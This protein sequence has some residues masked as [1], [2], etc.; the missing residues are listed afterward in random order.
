MDLIVGVEQE[1]I[2]YKGTTPWSDNAF[3]QW[4]QAGQ[5]TAK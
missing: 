5:Q 1:R 2:T 3:Q 4:Q